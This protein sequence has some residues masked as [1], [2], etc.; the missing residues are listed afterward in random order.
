[1]RNSF[2][3]KVFISTGTKNLQDQLFNKDLPTLRKAL[4]VPFRAALLKGRSNYLCH[5]RLKLA[6]NRSTSKISPQNITTN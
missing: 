2:W 4:A 1:S 3:S 5:Y 6:T